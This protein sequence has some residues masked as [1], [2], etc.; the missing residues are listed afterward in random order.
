MTPPAKKTTPAASAKEN[1]SL[2]DL[3]GKDKD[4]YGDHPDHIHTDFD[5]VDTSKEHTHVPASKDDDKVVLP[6]GPDSDKEDVIVPV[7]SGSDV[8]QEPNFDR[9]E[10]YNDEE[11]KKGNDPFLSPEV[12]SLRTDKTPAELSAETPAE[13]AKR[14]GVDTTISDEEVD[15]PRIQVYRDTLVN[16]VPSGTHLHPDIAKSLQNR[17]IAEQHTDNAQVKRMVTEVYDFA[18]DAER[19]DKF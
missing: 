17:G 8:N 15:N 6:V 16:Q 18:P 13:T 4:A 9:D 3:L 7:D 2:S 10:D 11:D 19:N 14:Y 12:V 5:K 1:K